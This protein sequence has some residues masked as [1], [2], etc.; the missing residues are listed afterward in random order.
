MLNFLRHIKRLICTHAPKLKFV[1]VE[2]KIPLDLI[3]SGPENI[4]IENNCILGANNIIYATNAHVLIKSYFISAN[5]LRI[6]SGSHERR[7]GRFC[8][9]IT[10]KEKN[11]NIGLDQDVIINEDVWCGMN[12]IILQGVEIGRGATIAAGAVVSKNVPPYSICGGVPSKFIKFY[13]T[14]DQ[15]LEHESK[16]YPVEER[17]TREG[18]EEI[19]AKYQK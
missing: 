9:S 17:Y 19:F 8:A 15:I 13:W 12:V 2:T 18:L 7:V 10:E 5:G 3:V 14:I 6:I 11:H 4:V 1:G 16:L